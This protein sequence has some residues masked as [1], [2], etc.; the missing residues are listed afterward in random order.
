MSSLN[1]S[2]RARLK[3]ALAG[4]QNAG[5]STLFNALTGARQHIANYPGVTVEKKS[6]TYADGDLKVEVVDLPGTY[7]L[8]SFSLEERVARD[9]LLREKP[10]VIV[11][12]IDASTLERGLPLTFQLIEMG[13]QVVVVVNMIDVAERLGLKVD[14]EALAAQLGVPVIV[15]VGRRGV[16]IAELR[17]AVRQMA[18]CAHVRSPKIVD[19]G[20]LEDSIADIERRL[21]ESSVR[22]A[23][24][25]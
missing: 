19:Y 22:P 15:C 7:S 14:P 21:E 25:S 2:S 11:N 20:T 6:G 17:A 1:P 8:T 23:G 12:V 13:V 4:Q 16:G 3:V 24:I 10:D 9:F 18:S 5:K